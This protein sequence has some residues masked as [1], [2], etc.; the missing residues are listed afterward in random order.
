MIF[1]TWF[2]SLVFICLYMVMKEKQYRVLMPL[3]FFAPLDGGGAG[4]ARTARTA[5]TLDFFCGRRTL[6]AVERPVGCE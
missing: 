6:G 4:A 5:R 2:F 3:D 1:F